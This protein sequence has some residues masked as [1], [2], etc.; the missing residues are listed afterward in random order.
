[1]AVNTLIS[2]AIGSVPLMGY[3][4]ECDRKF[5][6]TKPLDVEEFYYGHDCEA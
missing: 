2:H 4:R 5:D 1:V 6:M 3:C